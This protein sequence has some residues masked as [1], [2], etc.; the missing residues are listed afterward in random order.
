MSGPCGYCVSGRRAGA[1]VLWLGLL[2]SGS[3]SAAPDLWV[4]ASVAPPSVPV[5]AQA[6][7]VLRF[8]HAVDVS[9]VVL[10]LGP[11]RLGEV[12]PLGAPA[13][14]E[15]RRDGKRYRVV[16]RRFAVIPF[17]SGDVDLVGAVR[18]RTPIALPGVGD[19]QHL[20]LEAKPV[21]LDVRPAT[22]N[23]DWLPADAVDVRVVPETPT[24][25]VVGEVW[26]P[27]IRIEA[28]GVDGAS[29]PPLRWPANSDWSIQ[30]DAPDVG[31][32]I[33]EGRVVGYREERPRIQALRPGTLAWPAIGIDWV[34]ARTGVR[35]HAG[36]PA[37]QIQARLPGRTPAAA[38]PPVASESSG[39]ETDAGSGDLLFAVAASLA[40]VL[41]AVAVRFGRTLRAAMEARMRWR[42]ERRICLAACRSND[43]I[44]AGR[45][46]RTWLGAHAIAELAAA[47]A[48]S[49]DAALAEDL[50]QLD[51][52]C[53]G[54][55][56]DHRAWR[57]LAL[58][59]RLSRWDPAGRRLQSGGRLP[60]RARFQ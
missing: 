9:S 30:V 5:N 6:T 28:V 10:E 17:A 12:L 55:E 38:A 15:A 29:I 59:H 51:R 47:A 25:V 42:R 40:A 53:Y 32:R 56:A 44:A 41:A 39:R 3:V 34:N 52:A 1:A 33:S 22:T 8:G 23:G 36:M 35:S 4:E 2:A 14:S 45:A 19:G 57:G 54:P 31:R 27:R 46:I 21:R 24:A 18:G 20:V 7:Y 43:A 16:E 11:L 50:R 37:S 26:S 60:S 49:G 58:A 48:A 13:I